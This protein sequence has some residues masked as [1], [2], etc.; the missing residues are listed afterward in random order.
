MNG[1]G[2]YYTYNGL[3]DGQISNYSLDT[4]VS[5]PHTSVFKCLNDPI[6]YYQLSMP[7]T[8]PIDNFT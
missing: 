6:L 1:H 5:H 7:V 2:Y 3:N 8:L 4:V